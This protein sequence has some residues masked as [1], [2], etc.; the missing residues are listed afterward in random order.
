MPPLVP[1]SIATVLTLFLPVTSLA[2]ART[3]LSD[4][5]RGFHFGA[6]EVVG[7]RRQAAA[8]LGWGSQLKGR[9][10]CDHFANQLFAYDD[11]TYTTMC[12]TSS[13]KSYRDDPAVGCSAEWAL[14]T[15]ASNTLRTAIH[16]ELDQHRKHN[17]G[18]PVRTL[19]DLALLCD[20]GRGTRRSLLRSPRS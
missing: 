7:L 10:Y 5:S 20:L 12:R 14:P 17:A 2:T 3:A 19:E 13:F 18:E 1:L 6:V 4:T 11:S 9:L 16:G 8:A 15:G